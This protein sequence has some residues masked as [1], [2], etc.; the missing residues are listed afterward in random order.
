MVVKGEA[1]TLIYLGARTSM[2]DVCAGDAIVKAS[3]GC[4]TTTDGE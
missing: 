4:L 1:D 3:G 2:W